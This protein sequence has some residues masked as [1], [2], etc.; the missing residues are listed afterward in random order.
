[1]I[2]LFQPYVLCQLDDGSTVCVLSIGKHASHNF[3]ICVK[4]FDAEMKPSEKKPY[5]INIK[6]L[7][8]NM[9]SLKS[10]VP[11]KYPN[12]KVEYEEFKSYYNKEKKE[13]LNAIEKKKKAKKRKKELEGEKEEKENQGIRRQPARGAKTN[14]ELNGPSSKQKQILKKKVRMLLILILVIIMII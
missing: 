4:E 14:T 1:V 3:K 13:K 5:I 12:L 11:E 8:N 2:S 7:H 10:L 6:Q 9:N